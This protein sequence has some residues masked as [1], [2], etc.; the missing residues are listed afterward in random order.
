MSNELIFYTQLASIF[1]F[2]GTVFVLY[3][4]L[5]SQKDATIEALRERIAIQQDRMAFESPD[6]LNE[7]LSKRITLL[8]DELTRLGTDKE[9]NAEAIMAM[10]KELTGAKEMYE[11]LQKLVM[12]TSG[13][14]VTY[15]CPVC[16]EPTLECTEAKQTF[17]PEKSEY[18]RVAYRC[19]YSDVNGVKASECRRN[20][21]PLT[22][23]STGPTRKAAQVR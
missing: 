20:T 9:T 8:S 7:R 6:A 17:S 10:E 13:M 23:H 22:S 14:S 2:V 1:T 16:D 12:H 15:F 3:K 19:G 21:E 11:R 4:L 5:V 18:F